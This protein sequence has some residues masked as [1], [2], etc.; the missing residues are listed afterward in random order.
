[1]KENELPL[2]KAPDNFV[3]VQRVKLPD[4]SV[5]QE[6]LPRRVVKKIPL[7]RFENGN[8]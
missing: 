3:E 7:V 5:F 8:H 4:G 1:M 2:Q 6:F